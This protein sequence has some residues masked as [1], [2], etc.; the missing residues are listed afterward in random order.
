MHALIIE[1]QPII[2]LLI[3]EHLREAGYLSFDSAATEADAV[4]AAR[5]HCPDLVTA[6]VRL[7]EG[8][9][10]AAVR[11]ICADRTIAVV[12]ITASAW[13]VRERHADAV[14]LA[15][16]FGPADLDRALIAARAA[17]DGDACRQ[18]SPSSDQNSSDTR[19]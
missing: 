9:G 11:A 13:E 8:C 4:A 2:A 17:L 19:P 5:A 6:D 1:D 15:K 10:M 3:E 18:S 16:P 12:F 7:A 14:I